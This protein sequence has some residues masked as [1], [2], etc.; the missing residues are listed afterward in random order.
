MAA[1]EQ[2]AAVRMETWDI[3]VAAAARGTTVTSG[4]LAARLARPGYRPPARS[5]QSLLNPIMDDCDA[6]ILP[7]LNDLVVNH[8]SFR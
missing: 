1:A 4:E 2:Q 5:M 7:R 3:L 6:R 8:S